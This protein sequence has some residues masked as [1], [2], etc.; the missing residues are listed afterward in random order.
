LHVS[1]FAHR[2]IAVGGTFDILHVG[3]ER[4]L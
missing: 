2:T 1:K 3:H 4:L